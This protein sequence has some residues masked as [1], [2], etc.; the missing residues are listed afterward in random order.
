MNEANRAKEQYFTIHN[1]LVIVF[2]D[3][4]GKIIARLSPREN[5]NHRTYGLLICDLV[6]HTAKCFGVSDDAV[7]EWVDRERQHPT[8]DVLEAS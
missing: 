6:R 7:W 1:P 4:E 5:D 8:T 2:A 3:D